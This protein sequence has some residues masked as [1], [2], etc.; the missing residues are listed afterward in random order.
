[1]VSKHTDKVNQ[2]KV[3]SKKTPTIRRFEVWLINLDPTQGSEIKKTRPCLVV[4]PNEM[5]ALKTTIVAPMT[6]KGFEY[7]SRVPLNFMGTDGLVLLDQIRV[8]DKSRLIKKLGSVNKDTQQ[9]VVNC[10]QEMF[11]M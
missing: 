4:S 10:L 7:P 3:K 8:V 5:A 11:A 2:P 6:S 9:K 1:M